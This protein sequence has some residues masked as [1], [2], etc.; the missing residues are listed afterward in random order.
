MKKLIATVAGILF[1]ATI[2]WAQSPVP[3]PDTLKDPVKQTD[4]EV[5]VGPKETNYKADR[6]KITPAEIPRAVRQTLESSPTYSGWEK[7]AVYKN[8]NGSLFFVEITSGDGAQTF[9]FDKTGKPL[10]DR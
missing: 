3:D 6:L 8:E 5:K 2:V 7:A 9:R 10:H 4:P 1:F